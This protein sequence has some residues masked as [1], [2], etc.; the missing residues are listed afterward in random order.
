MLFNSFAFFLFFVVVYALYLLL[1]KLFARKRVK[2]QNLLL[3]VSSYIFYGSWDW[4]FLSLIAISTL[5][6]FVIGKSLGGISDLTP[7]G[8]SRRKMLLACSVVVNLTILGFFKYFR[9]FASLPGRA[10]YASSK[11]TRAS[12]SSFGDSTKRS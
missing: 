12:F 6:D 1:G 2:L 3:L 9:F 4:R 8:R 11:S 7:A 5:S 10:I